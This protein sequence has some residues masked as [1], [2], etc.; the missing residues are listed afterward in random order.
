MLWKGAV[1]SLIKP[2]IIWDGER[3]IVP[4]SMGRA[5]HDQLVGSDLE[6]LCELSCRICYS[7]LGAKNSR[8]SEE[9]HKHIRE[10]ENHSVY[11]HA[12][13]TV[14]FEK[15]GGAEIWRAFANRKGAWVDCDEKA[16]YVT[17]N[18][19]SIIEW[20]RWSVGMNENGRIGS[21]LRYWGHMVAPM[22][23]GEGRI[24]H[25]SAI[26]PGRNDNEKHISCHLMGSRGWSHEQVRH[27]MAISQ[28][29]S[30]YCDESESM[31]VMHPLVRAYLKE[32]DWE[33]KEIGE[34]LRKR[35]R[36]SEKKDKE[37]YGYCVRVLEEYGT[38]K[39]LSKLDARKQARGAARG[40][41]GNA[42]F[43]EMIFSA[44][45]ASWRW[46][47]SQR[48]NTA[49]DMEIRELYEKLLPEFQ[50]IGITIIL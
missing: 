38:E 34:K 37:T 29:S 18:L 13:I 50:A 49:A 17:I 30:R 47:F 36:E 15:I 27:R 5:R 12:V 32:K 23:V 33:N 7:S 22:I 31:Y 9:L 48:M 3:L 8:S 44:S 41:L 39:G 26:I 2:I 45:I 14:R 25:D 28:R 6:N 20:E 46:I 19:R 11:E 40:Y 35:I 4:E 10:V 21:T 42:L 43:T 24:M 1:M 16:F